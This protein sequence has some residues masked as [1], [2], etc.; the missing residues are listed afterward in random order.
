MS[1]F[2]PAVGLKARKFFSIAK[3]TFH[4]FNEKAL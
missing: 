4:D 3:L 2:L 1:I